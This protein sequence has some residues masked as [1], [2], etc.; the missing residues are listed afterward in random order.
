MEFC[1]KKKNLLLL[2]RGLYNLWN[3]VSHDLSCY[4]KCQNWQRNLLQIQSLAIN[5][6]R[7][8]HSLAQWKVLWCETGMTSNKFYLSCQ[9]LVNFLEVPTGLPLAS[10]TSV[11]ISEIIFYSVSIRINCATVS[12]LWENKKSFKQWNKREKKTCYTQSLSK[13]IV[14]EYRIIDIEIFIV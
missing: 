13:N 4:F 5:F 9:D 11:A 6:D 1:S 10:D 3:D 8:G 7:Q 2:R 14:M 12:I